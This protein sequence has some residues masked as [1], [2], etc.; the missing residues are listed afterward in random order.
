MIDIVRLDVFAVQC[1]P[2]LLDDE[3][4]YIVNKYIILKMGGIQYIVQ[5]KYNFIYFSLITYTKPVRRAFHREGR[6]L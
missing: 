2:K 6:L 1:E 5:A 3:K 4:I